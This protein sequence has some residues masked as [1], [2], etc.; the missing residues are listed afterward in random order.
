M[1]LCDY[2]FTEPTRIPLMRYLCKKGYVRIIGRVTIISVAAFTDSALT[3]ELS[4]PRIAMM[5]SLIPAPKAEGDIAL[6]LRSSICS[7][8]L[9]LSVM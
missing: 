7:T 3:V 9:L 5:S 2:S 4:L 8:I 1:S 6:I